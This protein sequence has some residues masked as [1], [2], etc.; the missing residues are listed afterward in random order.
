VQAAALRM[1]LGRMW[2]PKH[3]QDDTQN[4]CKLLR[5]G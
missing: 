3:A 5:S 4:L 2:V 1:T